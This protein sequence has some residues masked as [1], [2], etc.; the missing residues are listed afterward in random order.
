MATQDGFKMKAIR[1][2]G[3]LASLGFLVITV[4]GADMNASAIVLKMDQ[5]RLTAMVAGDVV[6]LGRLLSEEMLFVHSDGRHEGKTDYIKNMTAGDT[7]YEGVKTSGVQA[8][9][10]T[11]DVIVLT[12]AQEMRK[13]VGPTWTDTKL[14]FMSVW[15]NE[16]GT[17]RM[18]A[19]ES[20]RP[21]GNS[22]VPPKP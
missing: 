1:L 20:M 11:P 6:T 17:W 16:N 9:V 18:I 21:A 14:N 3:F 7:A 12:G 5:T 4:R 13:K 8:K 22:V 10:V 19:W 2:L 15:R